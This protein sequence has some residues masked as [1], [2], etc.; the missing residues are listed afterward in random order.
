MAI[1]VETKDCTALNDAEI[2]EMGDIAA[3]GPVAYDVGVLSKARD[4]WV[5]ITRATEGGR[6][7]GYAF[8]TLERVGGTP[9]VLIGLGSVKRTSRRDTALRA[10]VTDQLR[11]AVLAFPD[12]DVLI[13]ARFATPS[14]FE[15]FKPLENVIPRPGHR[16]NG[17]ERAWGQ[18]LVKRFGPEGSYDKR[19]FRVTGDGSMPMVLDYESLKPEAIEAD[20]VELFDGIDAAN[21]DCVIAFGWA[22]AEDLEKLL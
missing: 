16:A 1:D 19:A 21:G 20:V 2:E 17:E 10:L 3:D 9:A 5:L 12:E 22:M 18:R 7:H 6:L 11:R 13:G 4:E 14:G 8:C 15:A